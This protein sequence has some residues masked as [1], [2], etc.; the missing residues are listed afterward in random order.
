MTPPIIAPASIVANPNAGGIGQPEPSGVR[1]VAPKAAPITTPAVTDPT[2]IAFAFRYA[3]SAKRSMMRG[4]KSGRSWAATMQQIGGKTHFL[5]PIGGI[6]IRFS[7]Y[8]LPWGRWP[9]S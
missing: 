1:G 2:K 5:E 4:S 3:L 6:P 7:Q 9:V 8:L